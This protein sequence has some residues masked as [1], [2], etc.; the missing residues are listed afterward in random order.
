M[1]SVIELKIPMRFP[2]VSMSS[3]NK[4]VNVIGIANPMRDIRDS[5]PLCRV[6]I[7]TPITMMARATMLISGDNIYT[8]CKVICLA[9]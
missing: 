3:H 6:V 8:S 2:L 5:M 4:I 1:V 7:S 9:E